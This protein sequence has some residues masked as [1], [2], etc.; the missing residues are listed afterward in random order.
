MS[1]DVM[2]LGK[3]IRF[4]RAKAGLTLEQLGDAVGL[5]PSQLSQIEN[6]RREPKLSAL[7]AL[8]TALGV[9]LTDLLSG[10][11]PDRRS[12]LE[13]ELGRL[14]G[15]EL[16]TSLNLHTVRNSKSIPDEAL[17]VS[18]GLSRVRSYASLF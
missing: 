18:V 8:A 5:L 6:G 1:N 12:E 7:T 4:F 3:R 11:A 17:E 2:I 9:A 10:E 14:Q 16:F 15:A 13:I